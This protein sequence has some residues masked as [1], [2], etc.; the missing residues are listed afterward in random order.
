MTRYRSGL[1]NTPNEWAKIVGG[2]VV[3]IIVVVSVALTFLV[4]SAAAEDTVIDDATIQYKY[5]F[6]TIKSANFCDLATFFIKAPL[7]VQLTMAHIA[8]FTRPKG[9]EHWVT[10]VVEAYA[11]VP[12][13]KK[14]PPFEREELKVANGRI[15]SDI[16]DSA[17]YAHKNVNGGA[18]YFIISEGEFALFTALMSKG[19]YTLDVEFENHNHIIFNVKPT[20]ELFKAFQKWTI[21]ENALTRRRTPK[22]TQ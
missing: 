7:I 15:I 13:P 3:L 20:P 19:E 17:L 9:K 5:T 14:T 8:D 6:E 10:Y 22:V 21:C 16:F 18:S 4:A 1:S 12:A 11:A 2:S